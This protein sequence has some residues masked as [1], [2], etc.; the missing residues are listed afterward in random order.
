MS[1][2]RI[3][4]QSFGF[5]NGST[6]RRSSLDDLAKL[7]METYLPRTAPMVR[8]AIRKLELQRRK[9]ESD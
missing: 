9:T 4:Q 2:R 7:I 3:G 1:Q 6:A 8:S 5:G